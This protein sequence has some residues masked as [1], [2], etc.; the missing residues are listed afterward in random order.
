[1][2]TKITKNPA[3]VKIDW[4][5][6]ESTAE[7]IIE[8]IRN[9]RQHILDSI[10]KIEINSSIAAE[11]KLKADLR[12]RF[13]V[14]KL[15]AMSM[16]QALLSVFY[17]QYTGRILASQQFN[18][19]SIDTGIKIPLTIHTKNKDFSFNTSIRLQPFK[20][21]K[22]SR[23]TRY[24]KD[25][26]VF[27]TEA[28]ARSP[29][30]GAPLRDFLS[31]KKSLIDSYI[32]VGV[33]SEMKYA[34]AIENLKIYEKT[35]RISLR[36][37]LAH[38]ITHIQDPLIELNY[39]KLPKFRNYTEQNWREYYNAP[40]EVKARINEFIS[41]VRAHPEEWEEF[42]DLV[43]NRVK[44][45]SFWRYLTDE[46]KRF[47]LASLYAEWDKLKPSQQKIS[48]FQ[49]RKQAMQA[50]LNIFRYLGATL[51]GGRYIQQEIVQT[52]V[53]EP[54]A[55]QLQ[56]RPEEKRDKIQ[57]RGR[58]K[59]EPKR[60]WQINYGSDANLYTTAGI[61]SIVRRML[62]NSG[63]QLNKCQ[64][65]IRSP[66]NSKGGIDW[67]GDYQNPPELTKEAAW[68][69]FMDEKLECPVGWQTEVNVENDY[70]SM[71][72]DLNITRV[73]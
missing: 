44:K 29:I 1:M 31:G 54:L 27:D 11:N 57:G 46:N 68:I 20:R 70:E 55:P 43:K 9:L 23:G 41:V 8:Y 38:E 48:E 35:T 5:A 64:N 52:P 53:I 33:S 15:N 66:Y 28:F 4:K 59:Y 65:E 63:Y 18:N 12:E 24:T 21:P 42:D 49:R 58:K 22:A 67:D 62:L 17:P 56:D 19:S 47:Y 40:A 30:S 50:P 10:D 51:G 34:D 13:T 73:A 60:L 61:Y 7:Q 25:R 16:R 14:G 72:V 26:M 36:D 69:R 6:V 32:W 3:G 71:I 37:T 39:P 45:N 2:Q